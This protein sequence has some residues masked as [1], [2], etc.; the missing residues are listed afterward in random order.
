[1]GIDVLLNKNE[2]KSRDTLLGVEALV[3]KYHSSLVNKAKSMVG[4]AYA[5]EIVQDT[6]L[7][8]IELKRAGCQIHSQKAWLNKAVINKSINIIKRESK[9]ISMNEDDLMALEQPHN[10]IMCAQPEDN[11][12]LFDKIKQLESN[13]MRLTENQK[14]ACEYKFI[15]GYSN[16]EIS[17]L[18]NISVVN[19]RVILSRAKKRL[20]QQSI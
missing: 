17:E 6:W 4:G 18:M 5:E 12:E 8:F 1:M 13:W 2:D 11:C 3:E 14:K 19:S 20:F 7:T 15:Y 16:L 10:V 9:L